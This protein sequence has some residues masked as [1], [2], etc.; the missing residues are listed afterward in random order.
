MKTPRGS[1]KKVRREVGHRCFDQLIVCIVH[2]RIFMWHGKASRKGIDMIEPSFSR[3]F[4]HRIYEFTIH[5]SSCL[6]HTMISMPSIDII[7]LEGSCRR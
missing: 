3:H 4:Y 6:A 1:L 2:G 7:Y 5:S